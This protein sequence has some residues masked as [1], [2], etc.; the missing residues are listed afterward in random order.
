M[1]FA[2][3]IWEVRDTRRIRRR[4]ADAWNDL[5]PDAATRGAR[6]GRRGIFMVGNALA[7]R[8]A[9]PIA[10]RKTYS[11]QALV[12]PLEVDSVSPRVARKPRRGIRHHG[13]SAET[14]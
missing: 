4:I 6:N 10:I 2:Q 11:A 9:S 14:W 5:E 8:Q 3:T 12:E 7:R 1:G 13:R